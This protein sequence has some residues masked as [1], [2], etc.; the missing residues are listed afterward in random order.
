MVC[1]RDA[2]TAVINFLTIITI[3]HH[4]NGHCHHH[5]HHHHH[6]HHHPQ[7]VLNATNYIVNL[8]TFFFFELDALGEEPQGKGPKQVKYVVRIG[9][10]V[11]ISTF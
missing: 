7:V 2:L 4:Q 6:Y 10:E 11:E 8:I 5:H 3:I 1:L 9:K